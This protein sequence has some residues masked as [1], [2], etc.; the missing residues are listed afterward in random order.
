MHDERPLTLSFY[1]CHLTANEHALKSNVKSA[2][3]LVKVGRKVQINFH[4]NQIKGSRIQSMQNVKLNEPIAL[5][6]LRALLAVDVIL[7]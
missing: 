1:S 2:V 5:F 4:S 6:A 7:A 3:K